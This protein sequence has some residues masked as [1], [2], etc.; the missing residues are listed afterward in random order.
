M[1][2]AHEV[3]AE[4]SGEFAAWSLARFAAI[5][6]FRAFH[7]PP[8]PPETKAFAFRAIKPASLCRRRASGQNNQRPASA[9]LLALRLLISWLCFRMRL[10]GPP[11]PWEC[12]WLAPFLLV[13][14][15]LVAVRHAVTFMRR[16]YR[17]VS[18]T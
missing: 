3:L 13:S 16:I 17:R 11:P 6:S 12:V 5:F 10:F 8:P 1:F 2:A 9:I 18:P 14:D 15:G 7:P 4:A